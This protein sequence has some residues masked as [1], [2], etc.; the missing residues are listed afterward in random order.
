MRWKGGSSPKNGTTQPCQR[1][2]NVDHEKSLGNCLSD[3]IN[4]YIMMAHNIKILIYICIYIYFFLCEIFDDKILM[5]YKLW[6]CC[7][8]DL[9]ERFVPTLQY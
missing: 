4:I 2:V 3:G 9:F 8:N 6:I 5:S 1:G 7:K